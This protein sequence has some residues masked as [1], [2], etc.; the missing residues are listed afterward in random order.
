M[1]RIYLQALRHTPSA[2]FS[3]VHEVL[4]YSPCLSGSP[5]HPGGL[6]TVSVVRSSG[7]L[8]NT[9][10]HSQ[11]DLFSISIRSFFQD[12]AM[13]Q[14]T[15]L[16][17]HQGTEFVLI[18]GEPIHKLSRIR[19]AIQTDITDGTVHESSNAVKKQVTSAGLMPVTSSV[20]LTDGAG[21]RNLNVFGRSHWRPM[22][23][24]QQL[25]TNR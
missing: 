7:H 4:L 20:G 17:N 11:Q 8:K 22:E 16:T 21:R 6:L 23:V 25:S 24:L 14:D 1:D 9:Q 5:E 10:F 19:S 18:G 15:T 13:P 3:S 2:S 12:Q